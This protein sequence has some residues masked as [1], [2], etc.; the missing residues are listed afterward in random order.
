M[1][2]ARAAAT[3]KTKL[4]KEAQEAAEAK[5]REEEEKEALK[6]R[7]DTNY[8]PLLHNGITNKDVRPAKTS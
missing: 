6:R 4:S 3:N 7:N 5:Q 8:N 2:D 1:V